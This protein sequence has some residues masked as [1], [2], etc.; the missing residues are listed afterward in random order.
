MSELLANRIEAVRDELIRLDWVNSFEVISERIVEGIGLLRIRA[1]LVNGD[2]LQLVERFEDVDGRVLVG[3]YSFHWQ[4]VDG[5]LVRRWDNA[6]HH[7]ELLTFPH[8][9]HDNDENRV[10]AHEAVDV[11]DILATIALALNATSAKVGAGGMAADA[12]ASAVD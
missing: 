11:F 8:H 7:R 5:S 10:L 9:I 12:A 1:V 2:A 4:R 3:K 6:P